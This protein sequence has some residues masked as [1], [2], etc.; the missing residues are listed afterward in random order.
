MAGKAIRNINGSIRS[1][2]NLS[3]YTFAIFSCIEIDDKGTKLFLIRVT[4]LT[5]I[6]F[7]FLENPFGFS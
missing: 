3:S 6:V 4:K 7:D 5:R 2:P 1:V